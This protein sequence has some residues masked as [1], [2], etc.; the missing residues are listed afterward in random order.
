MSTP[1][2]QE[3]EIPS[4]RFKES[5]QECNYLLCEKH[6]L[7]WVGLG[8]KQPSIPFTKQPIR[9]NHPRDLQVLSEGLLSYPD[10]AVWASGNNFP[11]VQ[12]YLVNGTLVTRLH[13]SS[14]ELH[15]DEAAFPK[16]QVAPLRSREHLAGM[17]KEV[18][19]RTKYLYVDLKQARA[20]FRFF[21]FFN[22]KVWAWKQRKPQHHRSDLQLHL[23]VLLSST[24]WPGGMGVASSSQVFV[25]DFCIQL[26]R[27]RFG[28]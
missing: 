22:Y 23:D 11:L 10:T 13:A 20:A 6:S 17:E 4:Q 16:Q 9:Q 1:E 27:V 21:F 14:T 18:C 7:K 24:L 19:I 3:Q 28:S 8:N 15:L 5:W 2:A 26:L 12:H 25:V